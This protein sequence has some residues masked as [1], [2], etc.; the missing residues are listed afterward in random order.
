MLSKILLP[1]LGGSIGLLLLLLSSSSSYM[2][3]FIL[4]TVVFLGIF[5]IL[6]SNINTKQILLVMAIIDMD[7]LIDYHMFSNDDLLSSVSGIPISITIVSLVILYIFWLIDIIMKRA[8]T[9]E[10][11]PKISLLIFGYILSHILSMLNSPNIWMSIFSISFLI[12]M[13][14]LT[15]YIVNSIETEEDIHYIINIFIVCLTIQS[16][17]IL[18]EF[19]VQAQFSFTQGFESG[20][21]FSYFHGGKTIYLFRP[22]GTGNDPNDAGAHIAILILIVISSFFYTQNYFK[23]ILLVI[24]LLMS[25]A[26]LILTFSRGAWLSGVVGLVIFFFVALRH[27]WINVKRMVVAA[28]LVSIVLG[29]LSVPITVRLTQDDKGSAYS[30]IPLMK[31]AFEMVQNHPFIGVGINNF[32]IVLPQYLS[33]E[34]R[35]EW[36]YIVHNQY[37]LT[38]SETG[39]IGLVFF[40]LI[41]G[42]VF[43][44]CLR[45]VTAKDSTLSPLSLGIISGLC[46]L[47]FLMGFEL[48]ISRLTVQLFWIMIS[49]VIASERLIRKNRRQALYVTRPIEQ[50]L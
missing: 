50:G 44:T 1:F 17:V 27:R 40:L 39:L 34:I 33:S 32:G 26:A 13:F 12:Q 47:F 24:I 29:M 4:T 8:K 30:R 49:I 25:T 45:C 22:V 46:T 7:L 42:S 35:G 28:L 36:L 48:T 43:F 2:A 19:L 18:L 14:L 10:F 6:N 20:H 37:L 41:L 3:I 9:I 23:K 21:T 15:F 38:F 16:S 11:F 5:V 31:L